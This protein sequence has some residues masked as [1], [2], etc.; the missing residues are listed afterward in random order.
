MDQHATIGE[1]LEVR[2]PHPCDRQQLR[3]MKEYYELLNH[4]LNVL[5]RYFTQDE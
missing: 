5:D 3:E 1:I 4:S 2:F